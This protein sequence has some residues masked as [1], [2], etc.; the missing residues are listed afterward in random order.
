MI[1]PTRREGK[2]LPCHLVKGG[3]NTFRLANTRRLNFTLHSPSSY[4][5]AEDNFRVVFPW[6]FEQVVRNSK[7]EFWR[8]IFG[9]A[10]GYNGN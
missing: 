3:D 10:W 4:Y 9:V 7:S 5:L 2:D 1:S 8:G 6:A